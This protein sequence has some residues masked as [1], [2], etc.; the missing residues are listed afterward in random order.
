MT[1]DQ[2]SGPILNFPSNPLGGQNP[3]AVETL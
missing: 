3:Y 1:A 2:T